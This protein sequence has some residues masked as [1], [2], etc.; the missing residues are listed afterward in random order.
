MIL[1]ALLTSLSASYFANILADAT[2]KH[3]QCKHKPDAGSRLTTLTA[4]LLAD[5]GASQMPLSC[6]NNMGPKEKSS[7]AGRP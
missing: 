7:R 5:G 2:G 4:E 6:L 1:P 3:F